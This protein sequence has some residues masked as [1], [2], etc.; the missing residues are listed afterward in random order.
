M[1]IDMFLAI[2]N[3]AQMICSTVSIVLCSQHADERT[4]SRLD[5]SRETVACTADE[6]GLSQLF[7]M[8]SGVTCQF[9]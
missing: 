3:N 9:Q 6:F 8:K 7:L 1:M 5:E 2:G 4:P